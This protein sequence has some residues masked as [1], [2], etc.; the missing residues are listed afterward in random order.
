M[1]QQTDD[2][3]EEERT[4]SEDMNERDM[5]DN[6]KVMAMIGRIKT[7]LTKPEWGKCE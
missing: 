1:T 4:P 5:D 6:V 7:G 3:S 2:E